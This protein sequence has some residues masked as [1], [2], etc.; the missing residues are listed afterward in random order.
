MVSEID[1]SLI[2]VLCFMFSGIE[3]HDMVVDGIK[4]FWEMSVL[5]GEITCSRGL[6]L[7]YGFLVETSGGSRSLR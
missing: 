6:R 3:F 4:D 5:W 2:E 1:S 7:W